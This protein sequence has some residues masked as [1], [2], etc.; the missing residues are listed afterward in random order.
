VPRI[1]IAES[2]DVD[3]DLLSRRLVRQGFEIA[4]ASDGAA[5]IER[6]RME[7]P[8]LILLEMNLPLIDGWEAA[9]RLKADAGTQSIPIIGLATHAVAGDRERALEAGCDDFD[10]KPINLSRMVDKIN[11]ALGLPGSTKMAAK[12]PRGDA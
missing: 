5:A 9:R 4:V 11:G 10:S 7:S 3:R 8:D 12:S 6:A 2:S 1:L